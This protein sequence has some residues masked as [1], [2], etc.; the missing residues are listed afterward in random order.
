M[1]RFPGGF[2]ARKVG[3]AFVETMLQLKVIMPKGSKTRTC[4]RWGPRASWVRLT[5]VT[6][7]ARRRPSR[8]QTKVRGSRSRSSACA[9]KVTVAVWDIETGEAGETRVKEGSRFTLRTVTAHVWL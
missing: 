2:T 9:A 1:E 7:V 5:C 4:S 8:R 6:P 3:A